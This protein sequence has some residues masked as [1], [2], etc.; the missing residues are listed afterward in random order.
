MNLISPSVVRNPLICTPLS[1]GSDIE[2]YIANRVRNQKN[3]N[4]NHNYEEIFSYIE[5]YHNEFYPE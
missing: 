5:E 1:T 2:R 3:I 4:Q